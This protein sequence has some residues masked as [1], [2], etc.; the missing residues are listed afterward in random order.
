MINQEDEIWKPIY[1]SKGYFVSNFGN[2]KRRGSYRWNCKNNSWSYYPE[3]IIKQS[4]NNSKKY[5]RVPL[6][7]K[8]GTQKNVAVHRLVAEAFKV[9][10]D[11]NRYTQVNHLDGN[12]ANNYWRNLQWCT[13]EMNIQHAKEHSLRP[14]GKVQ[15][16]ICHLRKLTE[17]QVKQIPQ[18]LKEMSLKEVSDFFK[19]RKTTICEIKA[20][21]SWKHL[22]LDFS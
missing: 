14:K 5:Y 18:M 1:G 20:G 8:D 4:N 10:P 12:K 3:H 11:I 13:N 9:N 2:I 6:T 7:F 19:V 22:N 16:D 17:E 21:R 15:S